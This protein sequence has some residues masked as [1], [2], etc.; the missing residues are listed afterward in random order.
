MITKEEFEKVMPDLI[1]ALE[2]AILKAAQEHPEGFKAWM[3]ALHEGGS[4]G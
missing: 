1:K 3:K 2:E 4:G